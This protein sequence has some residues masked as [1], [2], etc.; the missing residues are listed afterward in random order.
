MSSLK[1]L[2][3]LSSLV[4]FKI[5]KLRSEQGEHLLLSGHKLIRRIQCL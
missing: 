3:V 1:A 4:R 2:K 5:Q